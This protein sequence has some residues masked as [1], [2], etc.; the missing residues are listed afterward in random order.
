MYYRSSGL[1]AQLGRWATN[2][3]STV[4]NKEIS[5]KANGTFTVKK[6]DEET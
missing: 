5:M 4:S 6:W 3:N 1:A 2:K